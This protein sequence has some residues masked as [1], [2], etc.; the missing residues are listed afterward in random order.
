MNVNLYTGMKFERQECYCQIV[1]SIT[2]HWLLKGLSLQVRGRA[3]AIHNQLCLAKGDLSDSGVLL[4]LQEMQTE[5]S[6]EGGVGF[7]YTF[8]SIYNNIV[9]PRFGH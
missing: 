2:G 5:Y 6:F 8:G 4:K 1:K 9:N 7:V 3:A